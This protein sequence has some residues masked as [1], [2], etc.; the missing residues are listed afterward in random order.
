MFTTFY[1]TCYAPRIV[2]R[3]F[4]KTCNPWSELPPHQS[5]GPHCAELL[6]LLWLLSTEPQ[7]KRMQAGAR[8]NDWQQGFEVGFSSLATENQT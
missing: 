3:H 7:I 5:R 6:V 4:P 2:P 1:F 8:L